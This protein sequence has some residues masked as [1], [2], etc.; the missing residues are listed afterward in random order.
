MLVA[1]CLFLSLLAMHHSLASQ[2]RAFRVRFR[3]GEGL[4]VKAAGP[5]GCSWLH[6]FNQIVRDR[7]SGER[8]SDT[9][10]L[11]T[12]A[13]PQA[14]RPSSR[15]RF[16]FLRPA[17]HLEASLLPSTPLTANPDDPSGSFPSRSQ[18]AAL[19]ALSFTIPPCLSYALADLVHTDLSHTDE[20]LD[21]QDETRVDGRDGND[22][23]L[24][25][26]GQAEGL[27]GC[28]QCFGQVQ[29]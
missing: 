27:A 13:F 24:Q 9:I 21:S 26:M 18:S 5:N 8:G 12:S 7:L 20:L 11:V 6:L 3:F 19:S 25:A 4:R 28:L 2:D 10:Q 1:C 15:S 23:R 16:P 14:R 17:D 22:G 29:W